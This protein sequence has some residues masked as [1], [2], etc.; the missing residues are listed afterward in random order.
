MPHA[1]LRSAFLLLLAPATALP[2]A[3]V[4]NKYGV[5][6]CVIGDP[7]NRATN[8]TETPFNGPRGSVNYTYGLSKTEIS[9]GQWYEFVDAYGMYVSPTLAGPTF[10]GRRGIGF[11]FSRPSGFG[12]NPDAKDLPAEVGW[13]FAAMYCNWLHNDRRTDLAA[14][15]TGAYDVST[16]GTVGGVYTDQVTRSPGAKFWIPSLDEWIKAT[17]WDPNRN[18]PGQGGYWLRPGGRDTLLTPALPQNGGETSA[19]VDNAENLPVGSYS[20]IGG[21]W[22]LLDSSG[23]VREWTE[24]RDSATG[25]RT[26]FGSS[27]GEV[28]NLPDSIRWPGENAAPDFDLFGI[29]LATEVPAPPAALPLGILILATPRRRQ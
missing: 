7:G 9:I 29:R 14:F 17:Y 12:L 6:F 20:G 13:R 5:D 19:F 15:Q 28:H 26:A 1:L 10:L 8:S 16:F 18:G 25:G 27:A 21:P 3:N 23:S 2:A 4:I 22:G 24:L 11:D